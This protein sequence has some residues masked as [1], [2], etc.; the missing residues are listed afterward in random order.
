MQKIYD[1]QNINIL[2]E[3]RIQLY[4]C[5]TWSHPIPALPHPNCCFLGSLRKKNLTRRKSRLVNS[6]HFYSGFN[7]ILR[8][9][10]DRQELA[11]VYLLHP[12][13]RQQ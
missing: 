9:I 3:D 5:T 1:E 11:S 10:Q 2:D 13:P 6:Y 8:K 12:T 7:G 4:A